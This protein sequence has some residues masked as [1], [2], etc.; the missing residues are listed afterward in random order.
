MTPTLI[1]TVGLCPHSPHFSQSVHL[2]SP[3]HGFEKHWIV[4]F[5]GILAIA[6]GQTGSDSHCEAFFLVSLIP[7]LYVGPGCV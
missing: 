2:H 4:S 5:K 7:D 6:S 3:R 1:F